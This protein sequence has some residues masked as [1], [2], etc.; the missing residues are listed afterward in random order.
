VLLRVI[1]TSRATGDR[2][3][4]QGP[5]ASTG[6]ATSIGDYRIEK[7][8][9]LTRGGADHQRAGRRTGRITCAGLSLASERKGDS[10]FNLLASYRAT[11]LTRWARNDS[12]QIGRDSYVFNELYPSRSPSTAISSSRP[13]LRTT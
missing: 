3:R 12:D 4:W 5:G 11:R 9:W 2:N 6:A 8:R 13:R 1:E 7:G 10:Y